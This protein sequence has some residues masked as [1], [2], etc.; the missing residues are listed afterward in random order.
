MSS[1]SDIQYCELQPGIWFSEAKL[2]RSL[3]E[4]WGI[5]HWDRP[6][7]QHLSSSPL[8]SYNICRLLFIPIKSSNSF[9][10]HVS[11]ITGQ[12]YLRRSNAVSIAYGKWRKGAQTQPFLLWAVLPGTINDTSSSQCWNLFIPRLCTCFSKMNTAGGLW[13]E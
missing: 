11:K 7:R 13:L 4:N 8:F 5:L 10:S 9:T 2:G 1:F 3:E 6:V 12:N